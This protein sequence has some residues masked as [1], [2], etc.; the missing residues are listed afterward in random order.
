ML[1]SSIVFVAFEPVLVSH[2]LVISGVN[3]LAVSDW[4]LSY[5]EPGYDGIPIVRLSP[6]GGEKRAGGPMVDLLGVKQFLGLRGS[7]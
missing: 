7:A 2:H 6:E 3:W 5:S 1:P 4:S